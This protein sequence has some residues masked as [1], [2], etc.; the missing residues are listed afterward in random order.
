MHRL[1]D[2]S[3]RLGGKATAWGKSNFNSLAADLDV[4][5]RNTGSKNLPTISNNSDQNKTKE[6]FEVS[7]GKRAINKDKGSTLQSCNLITIFPV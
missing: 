7:M 3:S 1:L 2:D 6:R 5:K 4:H